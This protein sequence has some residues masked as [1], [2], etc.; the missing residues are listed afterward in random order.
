MKI[1]IIQVLLF[2]L[3]VVLLIVDGSGGHI[4]NASFI[5]VLGIVSCVIGIGLS[6]L[7]GLISSL[8]KK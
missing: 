2:L 8:K 7:L 5:S 3:G 6:Q 4:A 1:V